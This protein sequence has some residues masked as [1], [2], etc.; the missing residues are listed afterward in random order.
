M[1]YE[2]M[3]I[4]LPC[5]SRVLR[6][7][8]SGVITKEDADLVMQQLEPGGAFFGLPA[9]WLTQKMERMT[10]EARG[11]FAARSKGGLAQNLTAVVGS[12]ALIRVTVNFLM[13]F[14]GSRNTRMFSHERD[15]IAWLDE[16]ARADAE[17]QTANP[18]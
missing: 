11:V 8:G 5:G 3:I 10:A 2:C 13:R 17:R 9:L 15:A 16:R 14:N 18:A 4:T 1:P 7:V 6:A 12:N